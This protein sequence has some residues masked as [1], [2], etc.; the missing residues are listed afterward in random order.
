MVYQFYAKAHRPDALCSNDKPSANVHFVLAGFGT[1]LPGSDQYCF[2]TLSVLYLYSI[3]TVS[4]VFVLYLCSIYT[5]SVLDLYRLYCI[6]CICTVSVLYVL[7]LYCTCIL[8]VLNLYSIC[9][10][11]VLDL[12]SIYTLSSRI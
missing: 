2:C 6:Y 11:P 7:Y 10:L 4:T 9:T 8:S 3:Y 12:Y 1:V 5:L